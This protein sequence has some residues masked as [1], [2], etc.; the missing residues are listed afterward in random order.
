M[1]DYRGNAPHCICNTGSRRLD[2][3]IV[4]RASSFVRLLTDDGRKI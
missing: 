1:R 3:K 2:R 4:N